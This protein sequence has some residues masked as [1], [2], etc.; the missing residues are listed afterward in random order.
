MLSYVFILFTNAPYY[1]FILWQT[2]RI[3]LKKKNS[4]GRQ[5]KCITRII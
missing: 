5:K 1:N 4:V 3:L 2:D